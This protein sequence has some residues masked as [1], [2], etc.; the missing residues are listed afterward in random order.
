[1]G[2]LT[3]FGVVASSPAVLNTTSRKVHGDE[4][5]NNLFKISALRSGLITRRDRTVNK[6]KF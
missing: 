1:M 2:V 4:V 6:P 3:E 5:L